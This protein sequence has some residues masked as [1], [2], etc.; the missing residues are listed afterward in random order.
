MQ[1]LRNLLRVILGVFLTP[2][3]GGDLSRFFLNKTQGLIN[4]LP[5]RYKSS[6]LDNFSSGNKHFLSI[7][8]QNGVF[9]LFSVK[10]DNKCILCELKLSDDDDLYLVRSVLMG[11]CVLFKKKIHSESPPSLGGQKYPQNDP[12]KVA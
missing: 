9:G 4:T 11:P 6:S 10:I 8:T 7:F 12:Q 3:E 2:R 1:L 5:K